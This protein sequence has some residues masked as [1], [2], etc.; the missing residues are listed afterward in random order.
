MH[1][2]FSPSVNIRGNKVI[3]D[4]QSEAHH[5]KNVLRL[6]EKEEVAVFDE[7]GNEYHCI[8][9]HGKSRS[10]G[11]KDRVYLDIQ[12]KIL[13]AQI[14]QDIALA[15]G[16]AIPKKAKLDEI[17]DKLVQLGVDKIIPL[18]TERVV[19][20]LDKSKENT[21]L[22]RWKKISLVAAKQ[23][24]RNASATIEPVKDFQEAISLYVDYDLKLIPHL[25]GQ[26]Q[27]LKDVL[28]KFFSFRN[29]PSLNGY[30]AR[31]VPKILVFIGP[32]GDFSAGEIDLAISAGF[33]PVS[34]GSLVLRV[35]T[36]AIAAASFIKLYA[37]R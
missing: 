14:A 3:I 10:P 8:I 34:L 13:A 23:S 36:A 28:D 18:N 9:S 33:I 12:H 5:L 30:K 6:R 32:E 7:Q 15:I 2:F 26:R 19:V 35:D 29:G 22:E 21:R 17:I 37:S 31:T 24:K 11:R 25:L 20:K 27:P 1:R 4:D 16:V